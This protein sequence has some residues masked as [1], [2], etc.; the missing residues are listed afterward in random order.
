[1]PSHGRRDRGD[2]AL[3]AADLVTTV[4]ALVLIGWLLVTLAGDA[5]HDY[6]FTDEQLNRIEAICD[7]RGGAHAT[8]DSGRYDEVFDR[9]ENAERFKI[10]P[11]PLPPN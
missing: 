2:A 10:N 9:C 4:V 6:G 3:V 5:I 8:E 7:E 1:M 11:D